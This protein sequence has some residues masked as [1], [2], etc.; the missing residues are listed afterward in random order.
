MFRTRPKGPKCETKLSVLKYSKSDCI[1]ITM[2]EQELRRIG[3]GA[4]SA[5]SIA[6]V[7]RTKE[8]VQLF[9]DSHRT[10]IGLATRRSIED[11]TPEELGKEAIYQY[12]AGFLLTLTFQQKSEVTGEME[13]THY[14]IA[15]VVGWFNCMV[16]L[17]REKYAVGQLIFQHYALPNSES[18][19]LFGR[20][21]R[22][23]VGK[24][25]DRLID[26]GK[27]LQ[28]KAI[29][30]A[31]EQVIDISKA[32]RKKNSVQS[33]ELVAVITADWH[34]VGRGAEGG[35]CSYEMLRFDYASRTL[36]GDWNQ[37]KV[38]NSKLVHFPSAAFNRRFSSW[39]SEP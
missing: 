17:C 32:L 36:C 19:L 27:A 2:E 24:T 34:T 25:V 33:Y 8:I 4:T 16:Q 39:P 13:T 23:L 7:N 3:I 12:F 26:E 1:A 18:N 11:C 35:S 22:D 21:R 15:T 37:H 29:P 30:F 6:R 10:K 14:S 28:E 38:G 5:S 9:F 31:R 20:I